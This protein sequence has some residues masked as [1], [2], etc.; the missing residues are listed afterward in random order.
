M[1]D[2]DRLAFRVARTVR[3]TYPQLLEHGFTLSD[4]EERLAPFPE[5]RRELAASGRDG[6]ELTLLRLLSG[7]RDYLAADS[8]LHDAARRALQADSPTVSM[9]RT[10]VGRPLSLRQPAHSLGG[11]SRSGGS[12]SRIVTSGG[13]GTPAERR[14]SLRNATQASAGVEDAD[15]G[16]G[17]ADACGCHFCGGTLPSGRALNFCPYCGLDLTI[18]YCPACSSELEREWQFCVTC[19]RQGDDAA[20]T[21]HRAAPEHPLHPSGAAPAATPNDRANE[22]SHRTS[23]SPV[24]SATRGPAFRS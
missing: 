18:R 23:N 8:A 3:S 1:D 7:E 5:A 14:Q 17:A 16:L 10:W 15:Q 6:Y 9:V 22:M 13:I 24:A 20:A 12:G 4:I 19:G 2:L 11:E 21:H